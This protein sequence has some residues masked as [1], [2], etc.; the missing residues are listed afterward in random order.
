MLTRG[1]AGSSH[2][3]HSWFQH[4]VVSQQ[5]QHSF[6]TAP[7]VWVNQQ[8]IKPCLIHTTVCHSAVDHCE[9]SVITVQSYPT[10]RSQLVTIVVPGQSSEEVAEVDICDP[11]LKCDVLS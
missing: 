4:R 9:S 8:S 6:L 11:H 1:G 3:K 2:I 10:T 7:T 5:V